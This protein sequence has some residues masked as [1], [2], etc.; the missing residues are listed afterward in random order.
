M[1][2]L[3]HHQHFARLLP[4]LFRL[5]SRHQAITTISLVCT[6]HS[7][8]PQPPAPLEMSTTERYERWSI[9]TASSIFNVSYETGPQ[10]QLVAV[11][12]ADLVLCPLLPSSPATLKHTSPRRWQ[13]EGDGMED[14]LEGSEDF[15]SHS[16]CLVLLAERVLDVLRWVHC[17]VLRVAALHRRK[18]KPAFTRTT[19]ATFSRSQASLD[20]K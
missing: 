2:V 19:L 1:R 15:L 8:Q 5:G 6:S 20:G 16:A 18:Y 14:I 4:S 7:L 9:T 11:V 10:H 13:E 12:L 17:R 3:R